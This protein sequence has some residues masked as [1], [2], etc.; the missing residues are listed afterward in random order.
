MAKDPLQVERWQTD[1]AVEE[2]QHDEQDFGIIKGI[3]S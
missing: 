1:L 2:S 3:V